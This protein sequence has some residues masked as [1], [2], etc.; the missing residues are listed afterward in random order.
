MERVERNFV[1]H[2][3]FRR[4]NFFGKTHGMERSISISGFSSECGVAA[5]N[6]YGLIIGDNEDHF[7]DST[8]KIC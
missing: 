1:V 4:V 2:H 6:A 7:D 3:C 5:A 8:T